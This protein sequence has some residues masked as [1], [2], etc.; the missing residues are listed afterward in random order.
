MR[1]TPFIVL[2]AI[3]A[4]CESK[5]P[6]EAKVSPDWSMYN[7]DYASTRYSQLDEITPQNVANLKQLC[8]YQLPESVTFESGIVAVDG[9]LYFTTFENTYAIDASSC[10]V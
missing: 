5:A 3:L 10:A 9:T 6:T 1:P 2:A 7:G 8:A 4:G